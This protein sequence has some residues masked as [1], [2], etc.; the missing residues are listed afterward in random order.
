MPEIILDG[1]GQGNWAK[2]NDNN[3][4]YTDAITTS[5]S[6]QASKLGNSYNINTGIIDLTD[7]NETPLIYVKNNEDQDLH[8][9]TIVIGV[10]TSTG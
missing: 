7:A 10:W 9:L 6:F 1:T 8:I 4:L 5:E 2:V 3:R